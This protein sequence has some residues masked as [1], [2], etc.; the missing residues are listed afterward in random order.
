MMIMLIIVKNKQ[1]KPDK[2]RKK[3]KNWVKKG[4]TANIM[5]WHDVLQIAMA[6][7]PHK[8]QLFTCVV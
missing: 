6:S 4:T 3:V 7:L 8:Y 2:Q 1:V 5:C